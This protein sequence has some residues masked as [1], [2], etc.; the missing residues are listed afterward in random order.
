MSFF[1]YVA[2]TLFPSTAALKCPQDSS[3]LLRFLRARK[4]SQERAYEL[5]VNYYTVRA[6]N[7]QHLKAL[8]PSQSRDVIDVGVSCFLPTTDKLGRRILYLRFGKWVPEEIEM[9]RFLKANL[10]TM[11]QMV[12]DEATQVRGMILVCNC[13][14]VGM[15]HVKN[16]DM[17][18]Q[19]TMNYVTQ[20]GFPMRFKAM[21]FVNEPS[22]FGYLYALMKPFLSEKTISRQFFHGHCLESLH[23]HVDPASLPEELQGSLANGDELAKAWADELY[24]NEKYFEG[25]LGH[26]IDL[27][28]DLFKGSKTSEQV[29]ASSVSGSFKKLQI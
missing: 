3:F 25:M 20:N 16:V 23:K 2:L 11:E 24:A 7:Q 18:Y 17:S 29:A 28:G 6:N 27:Q 19:R 15:S 14:D 26:K 10:L 13:I 8:T 4:F 21:H 1:S 22:L 12:R 5:L 9:M